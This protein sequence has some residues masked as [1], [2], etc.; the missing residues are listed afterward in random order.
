MQTL[1][2]CR[3]EFILVGKVEN[4]W[5]GVLFKNW[6]ENVRENIRFKHLYTSEQQIFQIKNL[7]DPIG[8]T[9][10]FTAEQRY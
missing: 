10:S 9:L 8:K 6:I 7:I 3:N 1:N 5:E 2:I 4:E